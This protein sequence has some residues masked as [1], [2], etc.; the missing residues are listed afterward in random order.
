MNATAAL[1]MS[2]SN[3]VLKISETLNVDASVSSATTQFMAAQT[4]A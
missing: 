4:G 3:P 1:S 2:T